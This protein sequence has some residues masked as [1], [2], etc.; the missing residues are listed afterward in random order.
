MLQYHFVGTEVKRRSPGDFSTKIFHLLGLIAV[1]TFA[2]HTFRH[3][4]IRKT[5]PEFYHRNL[6]FLYE[7][8]EPDLCALLFH[9]NTLKA[10]ALRKSEIT[11]SVRGL[12]KHTQ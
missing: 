11:R 2:W 5:P 9:G 4:K 10:L 12:T 1:H 6:F 3:L 8:R 7:L